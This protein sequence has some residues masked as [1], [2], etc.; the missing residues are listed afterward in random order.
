MSGIRKLAVKIRGGAKVSHHKSTAESESV[1]MPA[2]PLVILP[3]Q[4]HI[5][6]PCQPAVKVGDNVAVGQVVGKCDAF[7]SAPIHA[8]VS[9]TVKAISPCKFADG[10]EVDAIYIES[11]GKN[12][13]HSGI[14]RPDVKSLEDFLQAVQ[15]SGIVGMG[16]AGFPLHA[17]L[18]LKGNARVDTL[19]INA[20]ECEPYI[21]S[22]YREIMENY[23]DILA[24]I[25][26]VMKYI[27]MDNCI[28]GIEDNKPSAIALLASEIVKQG[29]H[30]R[31]SVTEL[32]SRYPYG[33]ERMI[34]QAATGRTI[35]LGGLPSD[36]GVSVLN[37]STISA[38]NR[39]LDT[40]MPLIQKRITVD[41]GAI[42]NPQN[43]IVPIGTPIRD[44]VSFCGGYVEE[45]E[46]VITGGPMMGIAQHN[47]E[48]P[49]LKRYN[50]ILCIS[51]KE[52]FTPEAKPCIRCG[53]CV[54]T[55][56]MNLTPI[57]IERYTERG[58][59]NMLKRFNVSGC[60]ECGSCAYVCPVKR[61]L[62]QHMRDGKQ[63][64]RRAAAINA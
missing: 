63:V 34:V 41:G 19:V 17:K 51:A 57:N 43:V 20:A 27:G 10:I 2:P 62:V 61:P 64:E 5:G 28:I 60:I 36:V 22:D 15:Q 3:M 14:K 55:C 53:R 8:T 21:T 45:P 4:Q 6:A 56:P 29:M 11:D 18:A 58:N 49:I 30:R 7:I 37:V 16:G 33:A 52:T 1:K 9:G 24:G 47:D 38:L 44:I 50:A 13:L 35:P 46:K 26:W 59:T 40:G 48:A 31:V 42:A 23:T 25:E 54:E 12:I 32:P 39:Y